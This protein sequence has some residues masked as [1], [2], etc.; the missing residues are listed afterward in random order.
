MLAKLQLYN[1][2]NLFFMT[3]LWVIP[4]ALGEAANGR[5]KGIL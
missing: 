5:R 3:P 2:D 4:W 1:Q